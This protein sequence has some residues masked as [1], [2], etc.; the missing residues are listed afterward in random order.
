MPQEFHYRVSVTSEAT[1]T[2]PTT[3]TPGAAECP[4][5]HPYAYWHGGQ[6]CC[7]TNFDLRGNLITLE[8]SSC[9]D[10]A[11]VKCPHGKCI[12]NA[13]LYLNCYVYVFKNTAFIQPLLIIVMAHVYLHLMLISL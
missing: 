9:A 8:S 12:N 11:K 3:A 2:K 5:S 4:S 7:A 1:I 10:Q 13:G 6:Y